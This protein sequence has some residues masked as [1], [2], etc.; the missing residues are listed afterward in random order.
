MRYIYV[1]EVFLVGGEYRGGGYRVRFVTFLAS[2]EGNIHRQKSINPS[3][4]AQRGLLLAG[5]D[6]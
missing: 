1:Y 2:L 3:D 6:R 4:D 5:P